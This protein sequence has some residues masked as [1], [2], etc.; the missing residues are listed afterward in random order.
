VP[1]V[2]RGPGVSAG[3]VRGQLVINNDFAPTFA[4]WADVGVPAF[5]DGRSLAP[6]LGRDPP[7]G[8]DWRTAILNERDK[9]RLSVIPNYEV[10]RTK[11]YTYV[12]WMTGERELYNLQ[13][14]PYE[15]ENIEDVADPVLVARLKTRL[16]M[17]ST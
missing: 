6:L 5:V 2:I 7:T 4:D 3:V 16:R 11:T 15:L 10:V 14:D 12:R 8:P 13:E 9:R 17:L 1:L